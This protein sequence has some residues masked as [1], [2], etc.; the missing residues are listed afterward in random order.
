V[1]APGDSTVRAMLTAAARNDADPVVR[2]VATEALE[3]LK[4]HAPSAATQP[5]ANSSFG[6]RPGLP[7]A[8]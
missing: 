3:W 2:K 7:A 5:S 6:N 4:A 1:L 8:Q